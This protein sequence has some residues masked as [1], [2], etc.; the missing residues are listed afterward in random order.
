MA[1][2][3]F[4]RPDGTPVSVSVEEVLRFAPVPTSGP[5]MGPLTEG[6]RIEFRN[7]KHQDVRELQ[8]AVEDR[9]NQA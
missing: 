5:L 8:Q 7:G 9:L 1:F 2:V 3:Q 6:T 4:T